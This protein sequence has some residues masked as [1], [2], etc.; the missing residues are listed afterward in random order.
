MARLSASPATAA[1]VVVC[2]AACKGLSLTGRDINHY[3][4]PSLSCLN[5][6]IIVDFAEYE[7]DGIPRSRKLRA[8]SRTLGCGSVTSCSISLRWIYV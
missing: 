6:A 3:T 1:P 7:S 8:S 5:L 4:T 2:S